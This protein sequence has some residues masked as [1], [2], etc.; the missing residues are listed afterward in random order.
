MNTKRLPRPKYLVGTFDWRGLGYAFAEPPPADLLLQ[1]IPADDHWNVVGQFLAR[2]RAGDMPDSKPIRAIVEE[3]MLSEPVL[4][5]ACFDLLAD[6]ARRDE[7]D[8]LEHLMRSGSRAQRLAASSASQWTACLELLPAMLS[9]SESLDRLTDKESVRAAISNLL[10]SDSD[11]EDLEL[12]DFEGTDS[13]YSE[14]VMQKARGLLEQYPTVTRFYAGEPLDL[15]HLVSNFRDDVRGMVENDK[16]PSGSLLVSRRWFESA[17]G[18]DCRAMFVNQRFSP[19]AALDLLDEWI[20]HHQ[21]VFEKGIKY[22]FD[23][24][25]LLE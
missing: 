24:P 18:V 20:D 7:I 17:T 15:T 11:E 21:P 2:C 23:K 12:Y 5:Y 8:F 6:T 19:Q 10:E 22:F 1:E 14:L 13:E 3:N 4:F 9:F 16:V 25:R